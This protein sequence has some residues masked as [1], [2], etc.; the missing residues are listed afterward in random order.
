MSIKVYLHY[1]TDGSPEKTSKLTIPKKWVTEKYVSDVIELFTDSYNKSNPDHIILKDEVHLTNNSNEK[2]YSNAIV[3]EV[4]QDRYDY[5]IK[6]GRYIKDVC[7]VESESVPSTHQLR[8]RNYGC[9]QYYTEEE[10]TAT[11]CKHH[12]APPIFHDRIKGWSCCK[13]KKAYD[14]E[15]FQAIEG[16]TLGPHS[17]VDPK[18][19]F[20]AS[21]TVAA[22]NE[23][24]ANNPTP[25]PVLKSIDSYNQENPDAASAAGAAAKALQAPRKSSRRDDGTA[26]CQ[27]KGCQ[28]VFP[29]SENSPTACVYHVGQPVFHD[30][31]KFWS[32]CAQKKCYDFDEFLAVPGCATGYHDD[33]VIEL[34]P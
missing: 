1:E 2:I 16:C 14:W 11:S 23:A 24:E 32:C 5:F 27:N 4:L 20:A 26:K 9:N 17:T 28:K 7:V 22:A 8:C 33:G 10:N 30:A 34:K 18:L 3:G 29:V 31:V 6:P 15:E 12:V 21:P 25:A 19:V 13:D